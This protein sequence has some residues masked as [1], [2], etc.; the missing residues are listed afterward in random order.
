MAT[1]TSYHQDALVITVNDHNLCFIFCCIHLLY[2]TKPAFIDHSNKKP[3][4]HI[5]RHHLIQLFIS[6]DQ[7][8]Y[9]PCSLL[10]R[11]S[12][13]CRSGFCHNSNPSHRWW[14]QLVMATIFNHRPR[15]IFS[16]H[17]TPLYGNKRWVE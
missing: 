15:I 6:T 9:T 4:W 1:N 10:T 14:L 17:I 13:L 12:N 11:H 8:S 2:R 3:Y 16:L 7:C 5:L